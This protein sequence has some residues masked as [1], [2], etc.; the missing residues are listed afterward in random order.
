MNLVFYFSQTKL[1]V[2]KKTKKKKKKTAHTF[3]SGK[4][5]N[6]PVKEGPDGNFS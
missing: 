4:L 5:T 6:V 2:K 3:S 1:L